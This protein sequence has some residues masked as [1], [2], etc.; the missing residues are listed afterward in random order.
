MFI[1]IRGRKSTF[2]EK[3]EDF[4]PVLAFLQREIPSHTSNW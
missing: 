3:L 1:C 2:R 4:F